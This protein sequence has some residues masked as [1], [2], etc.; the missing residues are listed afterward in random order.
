MEISIYSGSNSE[1]DLGS[2][3]L[4]HTGWLNGQNC[5]SIASSIAIYMLI[6]MS[7]FSVRCI[8]SVIVLCYHNDFVKMR[9]GS[10]LM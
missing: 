9:Q 2:W 8:V 1:M 5:C 6:T 3:L 4:Y 10:F 7:N